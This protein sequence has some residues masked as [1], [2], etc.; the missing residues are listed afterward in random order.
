MQMKKKQKEEF[1]AEYICVL[2]RQA[3]RAKY[4]FADGL[5]IRLDQLVDYCLSK[6]DSCTNRSADTASSVINLCIAAAATPVRLNERE[7]LRWH[8]FA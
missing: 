6:A 7:I 3:R 1:V 2:C 8:H 4:T 5:R